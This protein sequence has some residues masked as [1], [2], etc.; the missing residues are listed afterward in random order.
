MKCLC[1]SVWGFFCLLLLASVPARAQLPIPAADGT[2]TQVTQDGQRYLI[3]GG[4]LSGDGQNLFHSFQEFGLSSNQIADFLAN[5]T[6]RNI[7]GRVMGGTPSTIDGLLRVTGGNANLFLMN[8]SGIV[9]GPNARLDVAG[10]F[11]ATT[12]DAIGFAGGWFSAT[13]L[14]DYASL[15]G[16]PN[17][18]AFNTA[19]PGNLFNA[20]NLTV[21]AGESLMLLGGSVVNTGTLTAP[22]GNIT[23]A[24]VPGESL[25]RI[26]QE[27]MLLTLEIDPLQSQTIPHSPQPTALS[28]P[29]LLTQANIDH[30]SDITVDANGTVRLTNSGL[31]L[32]LGPGTT[33]VSGHVDAS[34]PPAQLVSPTPSIGGNINVLGDNIGIFDARIDASGAAGGGDIRLGGGFQGTGPLPRA[35]QTVIDENSTIAVNA[36]ESGAG[37]RAIVWADE[38][39]RFYGTIRARGGMN[40]GDGGFVEVSGKELLVFVGE[41]DASAPLGNP[42]TL[43]LDP[44]NIT[45]SDVTTPIVTLLNPN[46]PGNGFFGFSVA[47]AGNDL[48]VG[49]YNNT[50]G[51]LANAG[52]AFLFDVSGALLHTFDNPNSIVGGNFG[53]AVAIADSDFL[54]G[55][56]GNDSGGFMGAGQAFLFDRSGTL[57]HTFDNPNPR[58]DARFGRTV[59]FSG[60]NLL[61]AAHR[62]D[63]SGGV[64]R[65]GQAF[66]FDASGA[67]LRTLDNPN[68]VIGGRFGFSVA[69]TDNNL[70]VGADNNISG[71]VAAGQTFLFD[72]SGALLHTFDNPNPI[73]DGRF[74]RSVAIAGSDVLIGAD[75]NTSGGVLDAGQTF[76]FD[77]SGALLHTFDNPDPIVGGNFG[78]AVA[79]AGSDPLIGAPFNTSEGFANAGQVFLFDRS[80]PLLHTFEV[81]EMGGRFGRSVTALNGNPLIGASGTD[82]AF[83]FPGTSSFSLENSSFNN[84]PFQ[85]FTIAASQL[86]NIANLGTDLRIQANNDITINQAI[87]VNNTAGNGGGLTFQAGRSIAINADIFTD[88]G[89]LALIAND[90]AASGVANSARDAGTASIAT[91]GGVVLNAGTGSLTVTLGS[92]EGLTHNARGDIV[93]GN[94]MAGRVQIQNNGDGGGSVTTGDIITNGGPIFLTASSQITAG[95]IDSSSTQ[96]TGGA[97]TLDSSGDV[98]VNWINT[99]GGTFGGDIDIT[100]GQFFRATSSFTDRNGVLSS[101]SSAG[102]R[103]GGIITIRH[104]GDGI[105]PF[106]VGDASINGTAAAITSGD[107]ILDPLRVLPFTTTIGNLE[108][109][110]TDLI[111][112]LIDL[113]F[114]PDFLLRFEAFLPAV[115]LDQAAELETSSTRM[116]DRYLQQDQTPLK[117]LNN[118]QSILGKIEQATGVKPA[119]IY[120]FFTPQTTTVAAPAAGTKSLTAAHASKHTSE[121]FWQFTAQGLS[122]SPEREILD[123]NRPMQASDPLDLLLVT[124]KGEFVRRRIPGVTRQQVQ[125]MAD[126][127]RRGITD[128]RSLD[129]STYLVPAQQLYRWLVAPLEAELA[130][131]EVENLVFILDTG[132]RSLPLAA[133]HDGES[134]IVER[135]SVGLMPSL[136]LT[137][138]RYTNIKDVQ[139]LAMGAAEFPDY[140]QKPLPGVPLELAAITDSLWSGRSALNQDFTAENL[141]QIRQV[142]PF[143]ILHLA[144][145]AN[146]LP[147]RPS[148]SYIQWWDQRL[149]FNQL[150]QQVQFY[151]PPIELLVLSACKTALGDLEAELGFAGMA[152]QAGVKTG[153]G[154]LWYVSD[155]GT[156]GFMTSFYDQLRQAPIKAEALRRAQMAML[157]GEARL[158]DG[159]LVTPAGQFPLPPELAQLGDR[160]LTHPYYWS[161]FTMIGNP[162]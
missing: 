7:L 141:H 93:L 148:N 47:A 105:T 38:L 117:S 104:G 123:R 72:A 98:R 99:N 37:G 5:P 44:K 162:W 74:G 53:R 139:V 87:I 4:S 156:M 39:T 40:G 121:P 125:Q 3:D 84:L 57:L 160:Q 20:G 42:G 132:L 133:L 46:N 2:N 17:Q 106:I 6:L 149:S 143:G 56:L 69:A 110:S 85:D 14:N 94:L 150:Q 135:Y 154:S 145:H 13:G 114:R 60:S 109:I 115:G 120:V 55:A 161:A 27:G 21:P 151:D 65:A 116:F 35:R 146:F 88:N 86:T 83:L 24:A 30:A 128:R 62:N 76:L 158:E 137:D 122:S 113:D 29:A 10:S 71:G 75:R 134:F 51:A 48:L 103:E 78:R 138:T 73:A 97:V 153:L 142:Q 111:F 64:T 147:G 118:A 112:N 32:P 8:P 92:G 25:V 101:I 129:L 61:I 1:L 70:L 43:L 82:S 12:A 41:V 11:S 124:A 96:G 50:S 89:N 67:L 119:L 34:S 18:F 136:S 66:L 28:F 127:F 19:S 90:T 81:P 126:R 59:A 49:A 16:T 108:I 77:V 52:Q 140:T 26:Q 79:I 102:A 54:I 58:A 159:Q 155:E 45:I 91:A 9:F 131:Q 31:A 100:A 107:F 68:P 63:S 23:I 33:I 95:T 22:G 130:A 144:T 152:V 36:L 157:N 15:G 80:G